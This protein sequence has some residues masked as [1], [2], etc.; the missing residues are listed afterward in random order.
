MMEEEKK[1]CCPIMGM[2]P[3]LPGPIRVRLKSLSLG[4]CPPLA[5]AAAAAATSRRGREL[6]RPAGSKRARSLRVRLLL[7]GGTAGGAGREEAEDE[8]RELSRLSCPGRGTPRGGRAGG[9]RR[10]DDDSEE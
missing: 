2:P 9:S 4:F 10:D 6:V 8:A 3:P 1:L 5:A 7:L